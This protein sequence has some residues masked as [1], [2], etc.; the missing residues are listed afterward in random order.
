MDASVFVRFQSIP[1]HQ[2]VEGGHQVTQM[3][4]K[5]SPGVMTHLL[6]AH[7]VVIMEKVVA[8]IIRTFHWPRRHRF[9]LSGS[10]LA[11]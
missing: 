4:L 6:A 1:L 3:R 10:P 5:S 9:T 8:T 11:R 2:Y 7:T